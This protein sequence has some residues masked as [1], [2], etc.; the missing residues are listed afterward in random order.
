MSQ[1]TLSQTFHETAPRKA[2]TWRVPRWWTRFRQ[3]PTTLVGLSVTLVIV[4]I[5]LSANELAPDDPFTSVGAALQPPSSVYWFGTDDL[6]RSVFAQVVHGARVTLVVGL[7]VAFLATLIGIGIGGLAGFVGGWVDDALMRFTEVFQVLPRFF[8]AITIA[9]FFGGSV[10]NIV[11][12]LALTF[13]TLTARLLRAQVLS[14]REREFVVAARA[15]GVRENTILRR[16]VIPNA[17]PPAL[18]NASLLVGAAILVEAGLSFLGLGDR[19]IVSWGY[20]LNNAQPFLQTAWWMSVFPGT[21]L[22]TTVVAV[23]LLGEGLNDALNPRHAT[24]AEA[25]PQK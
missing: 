21:A 10:L 18:V 11:L 6:G 4:F 17:L 9:A 2:I 5:A 8:L 16:H 19:S 3:Q 12:V 1:V 13:W 22:L 20:M 23:N 14:V 25:M 7:S 15:I 24:F